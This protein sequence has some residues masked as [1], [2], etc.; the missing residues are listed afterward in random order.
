MS[1]ELPIFTLR[2]LAER[3]TRLVGAAFSDVKFA[4]CHMDRVAKLES[5]Q[6]IIAETSGD[7]EPVWIPTQ[8][9]YATADGED[10]GCCSESATGS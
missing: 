10:D 9:L 7:D 6:E 1:T 5:L 4:G 8:M 2:S 3:S